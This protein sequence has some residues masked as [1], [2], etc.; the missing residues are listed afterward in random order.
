MF[1][2]TRQNFLTVKT[3]EN[4][5]ETYLPNNQKVFC[6][7]PEEA[8]ILYYQ[9]Q[10]YLKNDI[11]INDNS[12]IFDVGAN[13]GLFSL[14]I[15]ERCSFKANI[16]AFEPMPEVFFALKNNAD[17]YGF[18]KIKPYQIGLGKKE[19]SVLFSYYPNATAISTM[20]PNR[21]RQ[22]KYN[23]GTTIKK[24]TDILPFP[25]NKIKYL[26]LTV[27]N[28]IINRIVDFAFIEKKIKCQIK[29]ISQII[30]EESIQKIDLLKIDVEK[31]ELDVLNGIKSQDWLKIQ[32]I[33]AEVHNLNNRVQ[34][35]EH[36]LYRNGFSQVVIEQNPI[37]EHLDIFNIYAKREV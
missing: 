22:S 27:I 30:E 12:I 16:Y 31:A 34:Y 32:Q 9:V 13:I 29:T 5:K 19:E 24:N 14:W 3:M 10:E 37:F 7:Q 1:I 23:F 25:L 26:P 2:R 11:S 6:L 28:F 18:N 20:C 17:K 15:H 33:V 35:I 4:L 36:L 8:K 21:S